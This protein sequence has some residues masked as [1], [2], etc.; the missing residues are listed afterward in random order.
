MNSN[1]ALR[2]FCTLCVVLGTENARLDL[3]QIQSEFG[4]KRKRKKCSFN[5][6]EIFDCL[7][8]CE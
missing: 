4:E 2:V 8:L 6:Q 1:L 3:V 7:K 5:W